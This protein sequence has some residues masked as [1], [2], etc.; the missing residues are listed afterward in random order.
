MDSAIG[1]KSAIELNAQNCAKFIN[2][3]QTNTR[4]KSALFD[5]KNAFPTLQSF[6]LEKFVTIWSTVGTPYGNLGTPYIFCFFRAQK[7]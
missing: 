4:R 5:Y 1:N 2:Y 7:L 3:S 6:E